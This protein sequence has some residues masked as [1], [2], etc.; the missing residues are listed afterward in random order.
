M[1][2]LEPGRMQQFRADR[3]QHSLGGDVRGGQIVDDE[4]ASCGDSRAN[5]VVADEPLG[6]LPPERSAAGF[7]TA[8]QPG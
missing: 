6:D 5:A 3:V 8:S 1:A 7:E 2:D 4:G